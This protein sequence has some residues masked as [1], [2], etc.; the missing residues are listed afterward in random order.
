M[1]KLT[2]FLV[3]LFVYIAMFAQTQM[4]GEYTVGTGGTYDYASMAD[5]GM[6]IKSAEFTGDVTLLICTDLTETINTGIV[7]KSEYTLT[8]RPDKDENRTITYTTATDNTG[9]TGV[10]VIGG[11]MTKT[12]GST[13]GW[14]S[15]PTKNVI[16]D[17]AAEGKTTPRLKI[18]TGKFGTGFLIYGDVQD[19]V[20]KNCI[21]E[22]TGTASANYALTFRSEN[23]S[24]TSK[25]I[26]PKNCVVENCI[27]EA[28]HATKS[29]AVY[30][31][32]DQANSAAGYPSNITIRNCNI[33][34]HTRGM[35]LYGVNGLNVEGCTFDLSDMASGLMCHGILGNTVKGTI[36]VKGNKF[37]KNSTKN[38]YA[39]EYGLQTITASGG[40]TLWVI[41]NNYF[42]GYNAVAS[43]TTTKESRLVG[44]RCG[45]PCEIRHNTF[46]MPKLTYAPGTPLVS[47]HAVA[48]L[49]LAGSHKYP[50]QNN[51]F[52]CEETTANV[53]LIRGGLNEN[54]T[55]NVFYHKGGNAAIVAAAPSCMAFADLETSYPDQAA[56][57][58]WVNVEFTDAAAG[59]LSLAGSSIGNSDLA[60]NRLEEVL[61]DITGKE[62]EETT[63]AGAYES[64]SFDAVTYTVTAIVNEPAMGEVTGAGIFEAGAEATLTAVPNKGHAFVNWTVGEEILTDNPLSIVVNSDLVVTANF[65]VNKYNVT[66]VADPVRGEVSGAGE[67]AYNTTATLTATAND[68]YEFAGWSNGSKENPLT[69]TVKEDT[70]L[71]ANF[72]QVLAT[73]IT[74][75][76]LPVQDYT[77]AI[78]GTIKRAIQNGE[79][80]IVLTHEADGTAHIYNIAH[81]TQTVIEISQEGVVPVDPEN[82]G[83]FLAISDIAMTEDGKLV[84]CNYMLCQNTDSYVDAGYKRGTTRFY[85]WDEIDGDPTLW[86]TSQQS[87]NYFRARVGYTMALKGTSDDAWVLVAGFNNNATG[88]ARFDHYHLVNGSQS[89]TSPSKAANM[90]YSAIG[91]T[92]EINASPLAD[93]NW[94]LDGELAVPTEFVESKDNQ[95]MTIFTPLAEGVLSKKYNGA[96]YLKNYNDH[97]FMIA[98]YANEEGLLAGVKVIG[99]TDGFAA[100]IVLATNTDLDGAV[101]ATTAAATASV[102]AEGKL[103]I[104]LFADA[105]VYTFTEKTIAMYTI[106]ATPN[107]GAMGTITG[108]G[109]Y[110]EGTQ[111]TITATPAE[112]YEFVNWTKGEEVVSTENPYKFTVTADVAL[113][114][115]FKLIPPTKYNVTVTAENGTVT[116]AGEYEEGK[117]ATLTAT[118]AEGYEFVNW[119]KGEEV[120]STEN[121]YKFTVTADVALVANFKKAITTITKTFDITQ[122]EDTRKMGGTY[123]IYA[124]DDYTLRIFGYNGAGTYQDDPTT[125]E[126]AAP[127]LFT[128][129]YDDALNAVVVV[130][131]D[132][133]NKK[134]VMQV[135]ATSEDGS[136]IYNLTI[137]IALPSYET[138]SLVA[139]GVKAEN[140]E[141]EG[142]PIISLKGEGLQNGEEKVPFDFMV[143]ESA[144]GYMAEGT[145]GE[146]YVF[147]TVAEFFAENGEFNFMATMQD[148]ES[149]YLFNVDINGTMAQPEV[150]IVV[151][152]EVNVTLY[153]LTVDVQGTMAMVSAGTEELSFWLTL[154]QTENHYG[155]Y[156]NDA[157]SN[158][159]YGDDQLYAAYGEKHTYDV[160]DGKVNFVV[161]F[162]TTPDAEGNVT[163]YNFTLYAGEKPSDP[164]ALDNISIEGKAAKA[165]INGQLIIVKDGVQYNAQGAVVK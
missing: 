41:E 67:Y 104:H 134:E 92:Y 14:A 45:D 131:L 116:G 158:I 108:S 157:F 140:G 145:V 121:P 17:G 7:N 127:M 44:I 35:F 77:P 32:G 103:T 94:V 43:G 6:A 10:F 114:A 28:T 58:K 78:K 51:I 59:D 146:I 34:G 40:A 13:I 156:T 3:S 113:V 115:N 1:K 65:A 117:E 150:E 73:S 132:N 152:E 61:T 5:A 27:L 138:Y 155:D 148:E 96:S 137:N 54:V 11:D 162:I 159:W 149:K 119:T 86:F 47:T 31:R 84:A 85:I 98:P 50:V 109:S 26:G 48:L 22:N 102:D 101:E 2:L 141:V 42:A 69:I 46:Y 135:T 80:T 83:D 147:S 57:S 124:D 95:E 144:E 111:V 142:M 82:A 49:W 74:L 8:I 154:L 163:K 143:F 63:Y 64:V 52:V 118:P 110:L 68:G 139:T 90:S 153:N 60:V 25:N 88:P 165:I 161:S 33:K 106:D 136:T 53:S 160:T 70:E 129:D 128:P 79:N 71:T 133:E 24:Q 55:G 75:N 9:P 16:V 37:I 4:S 62:R 151:K 29:Q 56:T 81:A 21:L 120:V 38:T 99:I 39:G 130:T 36:N 15:V 87:V 89:T 105:K 93:G 20:V 18:T 12:P 164:T 72:R 126:D 19:C 107:N 100:P 125:E 112:G 23:Y 30:F 76:A 66:V 91:S 123:L 97:H 122:E